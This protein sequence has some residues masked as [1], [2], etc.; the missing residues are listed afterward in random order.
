MYSQTYEDTPI[1]LI[2]NYTVIKEAEVEDKRETEDRVLLEIGR[3]GDKPK[4]EHTFSHKKYDKTISHHRSYVL[5]DYTEPRRVNYFRPHELE[6]PHSGSR[7][8]ENEEYRDVALLEA[9]KSPTEF[10]HESQDASKYS[11]DQ[12]DSTLNWKERALQIEKEYKKTACDRE[13]T[14]MKDMNRAFDLLRSK[15]PITKP[16]KKKYSKIECLRIAIC[17]IRHLEYMLAGGSP[18]DNPIFFDPQSAD[19]TEL[20]RRQ[21]Y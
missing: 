19:I 12:Q 8:Y 6:S 21:R 7:Y 13:R 16:S 9:S 18:E 17:Y 10:S 11:D 15:L 4:E 1:P 3:P 14:R 5:E 2:T 20:R